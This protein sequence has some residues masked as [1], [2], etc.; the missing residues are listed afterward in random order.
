MNIEDRIQRLE[1]IEEIRYL[2][3][4][5]QRCLDTRDF[6]GIAECFDEEVVSAYGNGD[7]SY[8]G[9]DNV[10]KFLMSVMSITM[11]SAHMIHGGEID[12]I[13]KNSAKGK[14]YLQDFLINKEH[15]VNIY[16]AA[17]YE[18]S[19]KKVNGVWKIVEIGYKRLYEYM[20]AISQTQSAT[21]K[22]TTFLDDIEN[23]TV[24]N[25]DGYNKIFKSNLKWDI[26]TL[27]K[28]AFHFFEMLFT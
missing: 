14:W 12:I 19:Y 9:K 10:I 5:Y 7:M 1:D 2:Q 11:P 24:D 16:G 3:A 25:F 20:D 17:I 21:L 23:K 22:K 8:K 18:N 28:K 6:N 4:K 13:G 15:K 27:I 26:K